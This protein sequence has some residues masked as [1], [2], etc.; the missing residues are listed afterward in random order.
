M[1]ALG[2]APPAEADL[3]HSREGWFG[4]HCGVELRCRGP[5]KQLPN[6]KVP[7]VF[8]KVRGV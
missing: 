4:G 6:P 1:S 3:A 7:C 8:S 5:M 2:V